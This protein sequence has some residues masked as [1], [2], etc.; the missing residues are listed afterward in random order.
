[1]TFPKLL[2]NTMIRNIKIQNIFNLIIVSNSIK[3]RFNIFKKKL[4]EKKKKNLIFFQNLMG[5]IK[6]CVTFLVG[7]PNCTST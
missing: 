7:P 5:P 6:F 3:H 4:M 2:L 1:M